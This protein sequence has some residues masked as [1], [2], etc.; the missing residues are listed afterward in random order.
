MD[1]THHNT[2]DTCD[3]TSED[4]G[5]AHISASGMLFAEQAA[6]PCVSEHSLWR[7]V[8]LQALADACAHSES[9]TAILE[10]QRARAW[11]FEPNEG[12]SQVC[13]LAGMNPDFVRRKAR[14]AVDSGRMVIEL[15]I[16]AQRRRR[17]LHKRRPYQRRTTVVPF[18]R[19]QVPE[20]KYYAPALKTGKALPVCVGAG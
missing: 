8:I 15:A 20:Q 10:R 14:E 11:F 7:A 3:A 5:F 1:F 4:G 18:A 16:A 2:T 19:R 6:D 12:F 17:Q 9:P 13:M